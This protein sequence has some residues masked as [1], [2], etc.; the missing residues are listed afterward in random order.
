[1]IKHFKIASKTIALLLC[2]GLVLSCLSGCGA[3]NT[4]SSK[5]D[6]LNIISAAEPQPDFHIC[7]DEITLASPAAKSGFVELFA[8]NK[9]CSFLVLDTTCN[10]RWSALPLSSLADEANQGILK[11]AMASVEVLSKTDIYSLNTQDNSVAFGTAGMEAI[12]NGIRFLYVMAPDK[13]TAAKTAFSEEDIAFELIADITLVD[14]SLYTDFSVHNLAPHSDAV[15]TDIRFLNYFG[16]FNSSE[17]DDFILVPDGCG[18]VINTAVYDD[19]FEPLSFPVY[20]EDSAL[21]SKECSGSAVVPA[22]GIR[23]AGSAFVALI[24]GGDSVATIYADKATTSSEYNTVSSGFTVTPYSYENETLSVSE[25]GFPAEEG[26]HLCYRFLSGNNAG[27]AGMASACREQLIRNAVLST[28]SVEADE[29]LPMNLRVIGTAFRQLAGE[30]G[31][32]LTATEYEQALDML[33]RMKNKGINAVNLRYSGMFPGGTNAKGIKNDLTPLRR[34]GSDDELNTLCT[35]AESQNMNIYPEIALLSSSGSFGTSNAESISNTSLYTV[36]EDKLSLA[37]GGSSI[38]RYFRSI[39]GFKNVINTVLSDTR[40]MPYSGFCL[41]DIGTN[42]YSDFGK[43]ITRTEAVK[44]ISELITPL[45]VNHSTMVIGANFYAVKN[46]DVLVEAPL[47]TSISQSGAYEAVPF[48]PLILHGSAD[49]SGKAF[50]LSG[51]QT[52]TLLRCIEFGACPYY[53]WSYTP[54]SEDDSVYYYENWI[55]SAA[56]LYAKANSALGDLRAARM[57]DHRRVADGVYV[58][59]YDN[60]TQIYVNYTD[61]DFATKG[62]VVSARNFLRVN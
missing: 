22:F 50:N 57:T 19:S 34:L 20:G 11:A 35:Y 18:A 28:R 6:T 58:T 25:F 37:V 46:A 26:I 8:D 55:N 12:E 54:L 43:G 17:K 15:I 60:G 13:E 59:E 36:C 30:K 39:S 52:E 7:H 31:K 32:L 1:M 48:V 2:A 33:T 47:T 62:I 4:T 9:T 21:P 5:V 51:D 44:T 16:A 3:P 41:G 27:Y 14:G 42:L 38:T 45:A 10:Q 56:E 23:H 53:E 24:T 61:K 49:Y 40:N 29:S